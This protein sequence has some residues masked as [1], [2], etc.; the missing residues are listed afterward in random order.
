MAESLGWSSEQV[1]AIREA[2]TPEIKDPFERAVWQTTASLLSKRD[3]TDAEYDEAVVHLGPAGLVDLSA[4]IGYYQLLA[5]QLCI[6]R[7]AS[8]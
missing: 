4:L 2:R 6:F 1:L 3:L 5:L 8:E 7:I